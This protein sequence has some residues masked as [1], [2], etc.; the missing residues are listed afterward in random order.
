MDNILN[1]DSSEMPKSP[2]TETGSRDCMAG[3]DALSR[4]MLRTLERVAGPNAGYGGR[5][6]VTEQLRSNRAELFKGVIGVDPS[7]AEYW[8]EATNRIIDNLDFTHEQKLKRAVSLLCDEEYQWWLTV[9]E[10]TEPDH[11]IGTILILRSRDGL[12][13]SFRVLIAPQRESDF[14]TLVEKAKIAEEVKRTERKNRDRGKIKRDSEPSNFGMRPKKKARSDGP[15]RVGPPVAPTGVA[16]CGHC[17]KRHPGE[18]WRTIGACLRCGSTENRVRDFLL[19]TY[20]MQAPVTRTAQ[21][22]RVVQ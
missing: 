17:G 22:L 9:K 4:A 2:T 6:S 16:H 7:V 20:Q 3:D 1:L 14:S 10:G 21:P 18:C 8:M 11:L 13:D 12:R 19:R 5:G 15:V